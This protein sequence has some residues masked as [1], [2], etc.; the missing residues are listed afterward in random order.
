MHLAG[1]FR[2]SGVAAIRHRLDVNGAKT[3]KYM[4]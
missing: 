1:F 4:N 2:K 3:W